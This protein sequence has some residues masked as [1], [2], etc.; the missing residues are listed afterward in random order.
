MVD[1]HLINTEKLERE[2]NRFTA[3]IQFQN[4]KRTGIYSKYISFRDAGLFLENEEGYKVDVAQ[5]AKIRLRS[6]KWNESWIV[7][8]DIHDCVLKAISCMEHNLVDHHQV[9]GF[10]NRFNQKHENFTPDAEKVL[11]D[12]YCGNNDEAAFKRAIET[13]GAKYDLISYL[14][15]I[16]DPEKYL[17]IRSRN[18]DQGFQRLGINYKTEGSCSWENYCGFLSIMNEIQAAMNMILPLRENEPV[19]LIDAHSFVWIV[20]EKDYIDWKPSTEME[21]NIEWYTE[22][23]QEKKSEDPVKKKETVSAYFERNREVV[24]L[25]RERANGICQLCHEPAPFNDKNGN[26]YLEVHHVEWLSRGGKDSTDNTVA[27][28]PNCHTKMHIV[29]LQSDVIALKK[30]LKTR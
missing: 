8:K 20:H 6:D 19:R 28:C 30:Q 24:R 11:F 2:F 18:F 3:F 14:F 7:S 27:L 16:K 25:T 5:K 29:D 12:I 10:R 22:R 26:P 4:Y 15:F 17:P 21:S 1:S 9:T 13:F 23:I